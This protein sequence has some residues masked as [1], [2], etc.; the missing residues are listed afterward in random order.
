M[1][2][3]LYIYNGGC[4]H[5]HLCARANTSRSVKRH[6]S[7]VTAR[8]ITYLRDISQTITVQGGEDR[9]YTEEDP[10]RVRCKIKSEKWLIPHYLFIRSP[11]I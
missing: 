6:K 4:Q 5:P 7:Y 8:E 2:Q 1:F 11:D 10:W 3:I 9:W